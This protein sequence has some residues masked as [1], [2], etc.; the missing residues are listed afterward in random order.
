MSE[1]ISAADAE[2]YS[3][4]STSEARSSDRNRISGERSLNIL[5]I[6]ESFVRNRVCNVDFVKFL[7]F[8]E[9]RR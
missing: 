9:G 3:L 6:K 4:Q 2:Y 8:A 5:K 7:M 1:Q